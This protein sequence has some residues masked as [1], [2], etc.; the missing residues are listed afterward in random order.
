MDFD[1]DFLERF[2][3]GREGNF[4]FFLLA[5]GRGAYGR[6]GSVVCD[7]E[8]GRGGE[9][10]VEECH[11]WQRADE[12]PIVGTIGMWLEEDISSIVG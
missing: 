7:C 1:V 6:R 5:W 11:L 4:D 10:A 9:A 3:V 8:G 12:H 2:Y